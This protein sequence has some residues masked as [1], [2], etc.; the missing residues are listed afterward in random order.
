MIM[1]RPLRQ[2]Y[3]LLSPEQIRKLCACEAVDL[4]VEI[5]VG[6][7]AWCA[8]ETLKSVTFDAMEQT[9]KV[10]SDSYPGHQIR[11]TDIKTGRIVLI[12]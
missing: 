5:D 2:S 12:V 4:L 6:A 10:F 11:A 9:L 3:R 8:L 7:D 1:N